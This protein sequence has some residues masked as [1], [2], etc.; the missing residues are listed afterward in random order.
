MALGDSLLGLES[1]Q[2]VVSSDFSGVST[3]EGPV[4][5][6]MGFRCS[7]LF[8][9]F[10][11][12]LGTGQNYRYWQLTVTVF[13]CPEGSSGSLRAELVILTSTLR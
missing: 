4:L 5:S 13:L 6:P 2:R 3:S 11:S 9:Q 7:V 10:C 1:G 8:G 12:V